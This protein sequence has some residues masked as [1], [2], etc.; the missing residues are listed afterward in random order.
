VHGPPPGE[1]RF[2]HVGAVASGVS[3][4]AGTTAGAAGVGEGA[5][6]DVP[7]VGVVAGVGIRVRFPP[8]ARILAERIFARMRQHGNGE[9]GVDAIQ[10]GVAEA[11]RDDDVGDPRPGAV[12]P[13]EVVARNVEAAV[14][15]AGNPGIRTICGRP[16]TAAEGPGRPGSREAR[17]AG[18]EIRQIPVQIDAIQAL[19][20][21]RHMTIKDIPRRHRPNRHP[22]PPDDHRSRQEPA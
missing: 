5:A 9:Q 2:L 20:I 12:G 13:E 21:Q 17:R 16:I 4:G 18:G 11:V 10:Q 7:A 8:A 22:T 15:V 1:H 19:Q 14:G 6:D 3:D